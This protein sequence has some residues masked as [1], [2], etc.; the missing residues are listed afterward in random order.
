MIGS[1]EITT[2]KQLS[3]SM[4]SVVPSDASFEASFSTA[5]VSQNYLA[6]YYLRSLELQVKQESEPELIPNEDQEQINLEHVLP[7][8]PDDG[9]GIEPELAAAFC[10][11]L[12]NL[13]LMKATNNSRIGNAPFE[14]KKKLF[15][16]SSFYLTQMVANDSQWTI[17]EITKRQKKLAEH[18]VKT[19]P[20][21]PK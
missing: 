21:S 18:A 4:S 17:E 9:W 20:A 11:R 3:D 10:R 13:V 1:K 8:S 14:D 12:G 5:R 7:Q 19:W 16:N 15:E 6:R 2:A